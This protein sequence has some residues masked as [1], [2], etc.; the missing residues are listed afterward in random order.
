MENMKHEL[1]EYLKS[2][3][4]QSEW[5]SGKTAEQARAMFTTFCFVGNVDADT[6]ECDGFL[7]ILYNE[8]DM[9][10]IMEYNDF[11]TFMIKL[12]V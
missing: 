6:M 7:Y 11:V 5:Y 10:E 12:I 4:I 3:M 9:K 8:A 2:F 1:F